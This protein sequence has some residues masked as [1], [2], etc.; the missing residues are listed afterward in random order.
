MIVINNSS[1]KVSPLDKNEGLI[2]RLFNVRDTRSKD[3][4]KYVKMYMETDKGELILARGYEP[5]IRLLDSDFVDHSY[6]IIDPR[7][8]S[9]VD[10]NKISK[11]SKE[12]TLRSDQIVALRK[13]LL[14]RRGIIQL[15]TGSGKTEIICAFLKALESVLG[16]YPDTIILE[17][18]KL[19]VDG[20]I[21]RLRKYKIPATEYADSRGDIS[22]VMVTH[23]LSLSRDIDKNDK[24]LDNLQ[25]LISDEGHHL[26][27]NTWNKITCNAPKL[28]FSICMSALV[29]DYD[30][31]P[32]VDNLNDL[33]NLSVE[34]LLVV[35]GSGPV[36][37]NL[38]PQYYIPKGILSTPY[39]YRIHNPAN[40]E[41]K[42][43]KNWAKIRKTCIESDYR[44]KRVS[45]VASF[46][47]HVN[48]KVLILVGTK[49]HAKNLVELISNIVGEDRVRCS[50]GGGVYYKYDSKKKSV[51]KCKPEEEVKSNFEIGKH[52][53]LIGTS[54]IY[55]GADIPN[56][57]SV[58]LVDVGRSSRKY[59]QGIGR[60]LRKTKTGKYAH[61]IDFT[62]DRNP[63][64]SYHSK[65][66][67]EMFMGLIGSN[68][69]YDNISVEE[70]KS[71]FS[72]LELEDTDE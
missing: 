21:E 71:I 24:L 32:R 40:E 49:N 9:R 63:I 61:V 14:V 26:Q 4:I 48:Y 64:L 17:P 69:I 47:S 23:P 30:K 31:I 28:E 66:R 16:Y 42:N 8:I 50:F 7:A 38:S 13:M 27:A 54:H 20:T 44:T 39:L 45:A 37:L 33:S 22:G 67:R 15:A 3:I 11:L 58:I 59:I 68:L 6:S 60:C 52:K 70:F 34:E 53:I 46:L 43:Y 65:L 12:V 72:K 5:W 51:V 1:I 56:L 55:E 10:Y 29:I 62:D 19:L 25:V 57:D 35:G 36:L 18:S 2:R 41:L